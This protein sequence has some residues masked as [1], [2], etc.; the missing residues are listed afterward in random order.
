[1]KEVKRPK[2]EKW[3]NYETGPSANV[4]RFCY[5]WGTGVLMRAQE[6]AS[7]WSALHRR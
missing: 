4:E 3:T 1:M 5:W 2:Y 7:G 6:F